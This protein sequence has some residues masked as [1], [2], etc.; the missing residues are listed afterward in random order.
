MIR[1]AL[2]YP[3]PIESR[4]FAETPKAGRDGSLYYSNDIELVISSGKSNFDSWLSFKVDQTRRG[5]RPL[6]D[7]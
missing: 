3:K 2:R 5:R 4:L 7:L 6:E 1:K